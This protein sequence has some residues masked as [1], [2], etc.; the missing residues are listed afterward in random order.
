ME[1]GNSHPSTSS[2]SSDDYRDGEP[3]ENEEGLQKIADR[4]VLERASSS[5]KE[6]PPSMKLSGPLSSF[7]R[8]TAIRMLTDYLSDLTDLNNPLDENVSR[9]I[10]ENRAFLEELREANQREPNSAVTWQERDKLSLM[11]K[12]YQTALSAALE[13][14]EEE[15]E[16]EQGVTDVEF[17]AENDVTDEVPL[18]LNE[19][20]FSSGRYLDVLTDALDLCE[21]HVGEF[22]KLLPVV[23]VF[24]HQCKSL[25]ETLE[26]IAEKQFERCHKVLDALKGLEIDGNGVSTGAPLKGVHFCFESLIVL[27]RKFQLVVDLLRKCAS[28]NLHRTALELADLPP[29]PL[30]PKRWSEF[31]LA[32]RNC[33]WIMDLVEF[34]FYTL[35]KLLAGGTHIFQDVSFKWCD[36][37]SRMVLQIPGMLGRLNSRLEKL[38]RQGSRLEKHVLDDSKELEKKDME[39]L[40]EQLRQL[41]ESANGGSKWKLS[42]LLS[43]PAHNRAQV[44][45][46]LSGKLSGPIPHARYLPWT[47]R[48]DPDTLKFREYLDSGGAGMVG[49]YTWHG[50]NVAV[51]NVRSPGLTRNKFEEEAA[52]LATVQHPNVVRLIGCGF[53]DKK[54]GTGMLIMELMDHDLRTVIEARCQERLPTGS[55]PFTTLVAIDII[56]QIAQ[57]MKHLRDHKVLHR[58]LKAKNILVNINTPLN[59][60]GEP[61]SSSNLHPD[62]S[63]VLPHT[64]DNYVAK[65]ADFGLAKCRP[66][67]SWV[68]TRMAGTT[69]WRAPEVF[70]VQDTE[71]TQDYKWPADVYSFG[72]TCYEILTGNLPFANSPNQS[73]HESV[74]AGKRPEGLDELDIPELLKDL[75]KKCWA[76]DPE[77]RPT[78][79]EIVKSLWECRVKAILPGFERQISVSR[80]PSTVFDRHTSSSVSRSASNLSIL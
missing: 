63:T 41:G 9:R 20:K 48:V 52:I 33:E 61:T 42:G 62:E 4:P 36:E 39:N 67:S 37:K 77:K 31:S 24:H 17:K 13:D 5:D 59:S 60:R 12:D 23:R 27:A 35:D 32:I 65:L 29:Q 72:M 68:R 10:E 56:M 69:G 55:G 64:Q 51:K 66:H 19:A 18:T 73:I 40:L 15:E 53:I 14:Q 74:M 47:F 45:E 6:L 26:P 79:D 28:E 75:V 1:G 25:V 50:E 16:E 7:H 3:R 2:A 11:M 70:H 8:G 71:V 54:P 34:A 78:F 46:F 57:A 38:G 44:A 80:S 49:K 76:T 22:K 21:R 30:M 58:D 43:R